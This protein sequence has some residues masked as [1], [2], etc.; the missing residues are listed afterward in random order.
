MVEFGWTCKLSTWCSEF[1]RHVTFWLRYH[2]L[3]VFQ[4]NVITG[5][6]TMSSNI[7]MKN[8]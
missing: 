8:W 3:S 1:A 7:N 5:F 4:W 6:L 2:K